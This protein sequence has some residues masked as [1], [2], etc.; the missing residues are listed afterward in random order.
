MLPRLFAK[1]DMI[2]AKHYRHSFAF[3][4]VPSAQIDY[5]KTSFT[6]TRWIR[7]KG[8]RKWGKH[9]LLALDGLIL[10]WTREA[11]L[12]NIITISQ[13]QKSVW[14][15][16]Y[17]SFSTQKHNDGEIAWHRSGHESRNHWTFIDKAQ[18]MIGLLN[19]I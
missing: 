12:K 19:P 2:K 4:F 7:T 11:N 9:Q 17:M 3:N 1:L 6:I 16:C 14:K 5:F 8:R 13:N 10:F 18:S 15:C